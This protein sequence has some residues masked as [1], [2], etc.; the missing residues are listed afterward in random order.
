MDYCLNFTIS[1]SGDHG[2][3]LA[4]LVL[5]TKQCG[6]IRQTE[7]PPL[8]WNPVILFVGWFT[9]LFLKK[10]TMQ[11]HECCKLFLCINIKS[12]HWIYC[13]LCSENYIRF[14]CSF[15]SLQYDSL[16][17]NIFNLSHILICNQYS[18]LRCSQVYGIPIKF[19]F[20]YG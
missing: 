3:V 6:W 20:L 7:V 13:M 10:I 4:F 16:K 15:Q 14:Y 11:N 18:I 2:P 17:H 9:V 1:L 12:Y 8:F 19:Y 5:V